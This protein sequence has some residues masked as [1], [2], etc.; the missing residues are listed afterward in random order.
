M[1]NSKIYDALI[2]G[3]GAAG[4][5]CALHLFDMGVKNLAIITENTKDG[6]SR[7]AGSDKQTYYKVSLAGDQKD[8]CFAMASDLYAGGSMDG[9]IALT[10]SAL[11]LQEFFHLAN[12]G[13]PFPF[14]GYGEY[15]GYKTD[16]D[17]KQRAASA[18][19]YTSKIM[20]EKLEAEVLKRRIKIIDK[21]RIIKLLIYY[22]KN[23]AYGVLGLNNQ[24]KSGVFLSKNM[25]F[26]AGGPAGLYYD[27]VY[28]ENQF[29]ASG[30]LLR[31]GAIASNLPEWQYG[32]GS[33]KF[34]WNLSGSYQQVL[35][36]YISIDKNGNEDEFLLQYFSSPFQMIKAI[37]N[38]GYQWSFNAKNLKNNG[39]SLIDLAVYMEKHIKRNR[40][41]MDYMHNP[42]KKN[43]NLNSL[44]KDIYNYLKNSNA[45]QNTPVNRLKKMN[46]PAFEI[47][48]KN[49]IDLA[50][51]YL[52]ID[53]MPQHHNGGIQV[54]KWWESSIKHLFCIG[55]IAGTH[56]IYRPGGAA[57]NSGQV[58]GFR[59]AYY[60]KNYYMNKPDEYYNKAGMSENIAGALKSLNNEIPFINK[61]KKSIKNNLRSM[62]KKVRKINSKS[63][64]YIRS[65]ETIAESLKEIEKITLELKN[66]KICPD[67]LPDYYKL[68]EILLIS[69]MMHRCVLYYIE[70]GGKS[71]GSYIILKPMNT[72]KIKHIA[73][74][75]IIE[76]KLNSKIL[77]IRMGPLT[78]KIITK[79][80][81]R[82][83]IPKTDNWF[84]KVWEEFRNNKIFN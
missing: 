47:Y 7:N 51:E 20:T 55:E 68:K 34:K 69:R 67:A 16:H 64:A 82:K 43:L 10:E 83:E 39:S 81:N 26:A 63:I 3:S 30:I 65:Q 57:L 84:E 25:I 36:R 4:Y 40:V 9:D 60:I 15:A 54:N 37:F 56:G 62:L 46:K 5:N 13:V 70:K 38:K 53:V 50:G 18:G 74:N 79:F 72:G 49:G 44:N 2:I 61:N 58:G 73:K 21:T 45:L 77:N 19:P 48:L 42:G 23:R 76:T 11:S 14:N 24:G 66:I 80:R 59:S 1:K 12:I 8:S 33:I 75:I 29:G 22:K 52:E 71:R 78:G 28:P 17:P 31:E 32:I 27:S 35:P 6:T 41:Y